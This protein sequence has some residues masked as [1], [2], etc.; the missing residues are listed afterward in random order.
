MECTELPNPIY[1]KIRRVELRKAEQAGGGAGTEFREEDFQRDEEGL[2]TPYSFD[3]NWF[4]GRAS[5][6][7]FP[8]GSG[9]TVDNT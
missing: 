1:G 9:P 6:R 5:W 4:V 2:T 3:S 7:L 8:A